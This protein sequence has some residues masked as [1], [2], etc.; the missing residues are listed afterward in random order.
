MKRQL[1]VRAAVPDCGLLRVRSVALSS[2][3][4]RSR[5]LSPRPAGGRHYVTVLLCNRA[6]AKLTCPA[7]SRLHFSLIL[8]SGIFFFFSLHFFPPFHLI[9]C[10][11]NKS[12]RASCFSSPSSSHSG[13]LELIKTSHPAVT[14]VVESSS[15]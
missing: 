11:G 3:S 14:P 7:A 12:L 6:V 10:F 13:P 1:N 9:S 2:P 4:T 15:G 5:W 8:I